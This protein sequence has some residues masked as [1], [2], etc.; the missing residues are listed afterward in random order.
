MTDTIAISAILSDLDGVLVDSG[1][2]IETTWAT[3]AV[4]RGIDP[5]ALA[6][7]IHGRPAGDVIREIAPHLDAEAEG[8][9]VTQMDIDGP[10]A[11]LLDGARRLLDEDLGVPVA[12]VTSCPDA[13]AHVRLKT[14]ELRV[15]DVLVTADRVANGKPDPEGYRLAAT[16]L[17]VDPAA[18]VVFE[19]A[20]AGIVAAKAA[21]ARVIGITTTH[22]RAELLEA[23]ADDTAASVADAL[24][25]LAL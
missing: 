24:A 1:D 21:G 13:L 12:I 19:D 20:P 17:G 7:R 11:K 10:P 8:A 15:P 14:A 18:A 25:R 23:G 3:W 9:A 2:A 16:E 4:S 22:P 5:D 6:G